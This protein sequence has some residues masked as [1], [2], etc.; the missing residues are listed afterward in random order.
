MATVIGSVATI[1]PPSP[2]DLLLPYGQ[3]RS[4][5]TAM[6][7]SANGRELL[8]LTYRHAYLYRRSHDQGWAAAVAEQ[9]QIIA[10]PDLFTLAQR[11][12]ACFSANGGSLFVTGEG[13]GAAL[14]RFD[15]Q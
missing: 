5:P 14:F 2:L 13:A 11:E 1:P 9:P 4:Q 10:L 15:R 12:A 7:L 3:F 8:I 6:D